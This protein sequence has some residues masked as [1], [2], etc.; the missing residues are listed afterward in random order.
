[1]QFQLMEQNYKLPD[2]EFLKKQADRIKQDGENLEKEILNNPNITDKMREE[3][4]RIKEEHEIKRIEDEKYLEE[5]K[6][7]KIISYDPNT[8]LPIYENK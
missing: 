4:L 3:Y 2:L 1:M 5:N 7:K 8:F 6:H